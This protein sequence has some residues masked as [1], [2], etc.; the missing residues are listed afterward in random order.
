MPMGNEKPKALKK[1]TEMRTERHRN[2]DRKTQTVTVVHNTILSESPFY[3]NEK[4]SSKFPY[5]TRQASTGGIRMDETIR[6]NS[7][8]KI[9]SFRYRDS[10]NYNQIPG[11][12]RSIRNMNTFKMKLKD[13][14]KKNV[15]ID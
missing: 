11:S 7:N 3:M 12:I 14:M 8:L 5:R 2:V 6:S 1:N 15:S 4:L 10:S 9:D 13:W